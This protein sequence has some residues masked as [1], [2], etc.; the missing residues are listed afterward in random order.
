MENC[1]QL[2]IE[3]GLLVIDSTLPDCAN[4]TWPFT[5]VGPVGFPYAISATKH[6]ATAAATSLRRKRV[7]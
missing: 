6:A 4:V 5:T 7:S 1:C 2:M 3:L